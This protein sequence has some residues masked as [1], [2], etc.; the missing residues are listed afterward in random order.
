MVEITTSRTIPVRASEVW[1][2]LEDFGSFYQVNP[3]LRCSPVTNG[4]G[5]G[6]GAERECL[7]Y[8][9]STIRERVSAVQAGESL[10]LTITQTSLPISSGQ[11]NVR[12]TAEDDERSRVTFDVRVTPKY[13]MVGRLLGALFMKPILKSRFNIVLRGIATY[14]ATG[15]EVGPGTALLSV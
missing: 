14:L 12:V 1:R 9:G 4:I 8:D 11:I 2:V 10:D 13:G 6:V 7:F 15:E 5:S 3:L